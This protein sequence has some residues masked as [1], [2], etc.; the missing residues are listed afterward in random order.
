MFGVDLPLAN[1]VTCLQASHKDSQ[2]QGYSSGSTVKISPSGAEEENLT[3]DLSVTVCVW[4]AFLFS[5]LLTT[6]PSSGLVTREVKCF[7]TR[8]TSVLVF[9]L[10]G[11]LSDPDRL[12]PG[13]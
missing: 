12:A 5:M 13:L 7:S 11:V 2:Q 9:L 4:V 6:S 10:G 1:P 8:Q 3:A